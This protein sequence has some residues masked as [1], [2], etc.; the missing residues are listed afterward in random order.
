MTAVGGNIWSSERCPDW[1]RFCMERYTTTIRG[2]TMMTITAVSPSIRDD[3]LDFWPMY[4]AR[5]R[6]ALVSDFGLVPWRPFGTLHVGIATYHEQHEWTPAE[7]AVYIEQ[8]K[9]HQALLEENRSWWRFV[10]E[11]QRFI[12]PDA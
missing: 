3:F 6:K 1:G 2:R 9:H 5:R 7:Y 12:G 10:D 8:Y 11:L 4:D